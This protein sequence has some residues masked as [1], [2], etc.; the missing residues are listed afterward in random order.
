[1]E[2]GRREGKVKL[3]GKRKMNNK[4]KVKKGKKCVKRC[5]DD[6]KQKNGDVTMGNGKDWEEEATGTKRGERKGEK[7]DKQR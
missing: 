2:N 4:K 6:K 1:M 7:R 3:R 5:R